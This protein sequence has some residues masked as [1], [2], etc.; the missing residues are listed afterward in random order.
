M[1]TVLALDQSSRTS[2]W[3]VFIDGTLFAQGNFTKSQND[4]GQRL[5]AIRHEVLALI[6][7]YGVTEIVF[8]DI[9][10]QNSVGNNVDTFKKLAEVFGII[11]ELSVDLNIPATAMHPVSWRSAVGI[12]GRTRPEQ[13]KAAQAHVATK[14]NLKVSE[15][16]SDAI[17]IGEAYLKGTQGQL[18]ADYDWD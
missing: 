18:A 10:L 5:H 7:Q 2:G 15:D 1:R 16:T 12:K 14:Y 9:Q 11:L 3:A 13:K 4:F 8:E 17:C 6:N